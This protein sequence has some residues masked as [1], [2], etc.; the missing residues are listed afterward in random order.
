[1][2]DS[3]AILAAVK[4]NHAQ[5][6]ACACHDFRKLPGNHFAPRYRCVH[7]AGEIDAIAHHWYA[8]GLAHGATAK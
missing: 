1:M 7:C 8:R 5:L 4:E 2:I 3:Q 6:N